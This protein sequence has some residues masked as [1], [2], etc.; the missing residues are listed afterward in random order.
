[1]Q[2]EFTLRKK[3]GIGDVISDSFSYYR[4]H[5]VQLMKVLLVIPTPLIIIGAIFTGIFY[6]DFLQSTF[7]NNRSGMES[8]LPYLFLGFF[9]LGLGYL[10]LQ[11]VVVEYMNISEK[12]E[13]ANITFSM[14]INAL[15]K[16]LLNY[17]L[18]FLL[19]LL[20]L[21]VGIVFFILPGIFLYVIFSIYFYPIAVE[22]KDPGASI[23][24]SFELIWGKWWFSFVIYLIMS[25]IVS[26]ITY[27]LSFPLA[28]LTGFSGFSSQDPQVLQESLNT[29]ATVQFPIQMIISSLLASLF[30]VAIGINYY[31]IVEEKEEIGLK[32][33]IDAIEESESKVIEEGSAKD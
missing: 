12:E 31:S 15:K 22:R 13:K 21:S 2:N 8:N 20:I 4:I 29:F 7:T 6:S 16:N 25:I 26:S 9:I 5:F 3:R 19:L 11:V 1:M 14:I 28:L 27:A 32:Q 30:I 10:L 17:I 18:G 23:K 24:R 33:K